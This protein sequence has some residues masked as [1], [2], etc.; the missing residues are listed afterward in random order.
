MEDA[1]REGDQRGHEPVDEEIP[2]K[3]E[4]DRNNSG[5]LLRT[6]WTIEK[7]RWLYL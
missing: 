2:H 1:K 6:S 4:R 7:V 3:L 5:D